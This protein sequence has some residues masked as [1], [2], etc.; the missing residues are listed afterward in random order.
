MH[1]SRYHALGNDYL[2]IPPG[3]LPIT[4]DRARALCDRHYGVG[5]DGL[6]LGPIPVQDADFGLRIFNP[7][8]SEAEKSG[9]GLRIFARHLWDQGLVQEAPFTVHTPGG[10]VRCTVHPGGQQVGVE[11]GRPSFDSL[12]IPMSGPP[13]EVVGET[14][15]L[16]GEELSICAVSLG[17]PHCVV[18]DR[19]V[20]RAE[21]VRLGPLIE[22]H[23]V[24]PRRTN[25]QLL[26]IL[27]RRNIRIEIWERGA[28]YTLSSGTSSCAAAA[29]AHRLGACDPEITVHTPGGPLQVSIALDLNLTLTGPV[30]RICTGKIHLDEI[31][32]P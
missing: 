11:M 30:A 16:A 13:R 6:L 27:D 21:V 18:L 2:V 7:D 1:F 24:F 31:F 23:P 26:H 28:G 10:I 15:V 9:N 25:V 4:P 19:P 3:P 29:V 14:L 32:I 20:T 8:G 22:N 17:N 12:T 5:A